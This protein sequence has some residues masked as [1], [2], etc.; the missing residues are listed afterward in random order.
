[1]SIFVVFD[2]IFR[3]YL[4]ISDGISVGNMNFKFFKNRA[5]IDGIF[6]SV[7]FQME[8]LVGKFKKFAFPTEY[9]RR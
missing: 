7:T 1:M 2:K 3:R 6:P 8:N 5:I 4:D 9:I